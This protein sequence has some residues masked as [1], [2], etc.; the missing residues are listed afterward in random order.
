[1]TIEEIRRIPLLSEIN[2]AVFSGLLAK[3][4]IFVRHYAKGVTVHNQHD[5]CNV[6]DIVLSGN[7]E[8]YALSEN[9]SAMTMFEFRESSIIGAN[10]LFGENS[11]YPLNIYSVTAC[12]LLHLTRAAAAELLHDYQFVMQYIKSL[13]VNSQGMNRKISM[14][15]QKTLRENVMDY[16]RG[17]SLAQGSSDVVLPISK[18]E[19]ADYLGVQRPSLFRVLKALKDEKIID[20]HNRTI[21]LLQ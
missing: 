10:L 5:T 2:T 17:Q 9:G 13:S 20:T 21:T 15:T 8:A 12:N 4:Q 18:K 1:M 16:L 6:L 3:N 14:L 19:L 7:L 11:V